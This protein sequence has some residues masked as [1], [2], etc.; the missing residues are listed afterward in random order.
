[1]RFHFVM[2]LFLLGIWVMNNFRGESE[3]TPQGCRALQGM[4]KSIY[5]YMYGP[6]HIERKT[7]GRMNRERDDDD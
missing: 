7:N 5:I 3:E 2:T 1:M 6:C 4:I